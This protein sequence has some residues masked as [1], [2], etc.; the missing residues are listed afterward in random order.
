MKS[1]SCA[2]TADTSR[3]HSWVDLNF[4]PGLL[5]PFSGIWIDLSVTCLGLFCDEMRFGEKCWGKCRKDKCAGVLLLQ[6]NTVRKTAILTN[7]ANI[8]DRIIFKIALD[9]AN[10]LM[11]KL[12]TQTGLF[13]HDQGTQEHFKS[14]WVPMTLKPLTTLDWQ[15]SPYL[16]T[17]RT[18]LSSWASK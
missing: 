16:E 4:N 9:S 13:F 14:P 5:T 18:Q 12:K 6:Q 17:F 1:N 10:C 15:H 2:W 7:L 3:K 11:R 8:L